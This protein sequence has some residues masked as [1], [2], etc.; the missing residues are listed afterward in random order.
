[1]TRQPEGL[2][3][4]DENSPGPSNRSQWNPAELGMVAVASWFVGCLAT[5]CFVGI[6]RLASV[7]NWQANT[8][9]A[10]PKTMVQVA[11]GSLLAA[12]AIVV[13]GTQSNH[14]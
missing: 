10:G 2:Q 1:M 5:L 12:V 6:E 4:D 7:L 3:S 14:Q 8:N 9:P 13:L 11:A